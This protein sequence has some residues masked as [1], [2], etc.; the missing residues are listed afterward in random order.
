MMSFKRPPA[1]TLASILAVACCTELPATPGDA[2]DPWSKVQAALA[3][4]DTT[5][6][7]P[8]EE[9]TADGAPVRQGPKVLFR[10]KADD[11][12]VKRVHLAGNFN[13]WA[14]N[15]EGEVLNEL[16]VMQPVEGGRWYRR[17]EL[18]PGQYAYQYIIERQDGTFDWLKDPHAEES[19][20]EGHSI[21]RIAPCKEGV[22]PSGTEQDNLAAS[23]LAG[24][25][26]DGTNRILSVRKT[27]VRPGETNEVETAPW[28][29]EAGR[30]V[31]VEV[32]TPLGRSIHRAEHEVGPGT[33]TLPVPA[34]ETEGGYVL[35]VK[36]GGDGNDTV[37]GRTVLTVADSIADD[38][39]YGFYASYGSTEGDYD[40][41][42]AML[43]AMHVNAVEFYDY[44]PAHGKYAPTEFEYEFE[45]FGIAINAEDVK[46]KIDSGH[47]R[48]ILAIAYVAA[49]AASQSVY[50]Q[51]PYPMTD[52][53]GRPKVFNGEIMTEEEA[54][55]QGKP[56]WFR[57]MNIAKDS[58]WREYVLEE[59]RRTLD[60]SPD[61]L[62]AFDGFEIDTYGDS[63]GTKFYAEGSAHNGEYLTDVLRDFVDETR[64]VTRSVKPHGLVSFNSINEFG[65]SDMVNVTDFLFLE[66]WRFYNPE[67]GGLVDICFR[68]RAPARQRVVLKL[69]PADMDPKQK[70]WPAGTLARILGATMTG[71]GSLM[72][73][74]EPDEKNSTMHGLNSLFYPDHQPLR[75][76]NAELIR[77]YYGHDAM[78]FGYTHG[79]NVH[80]TAIDA[81]LEGAITRT[82]AAEGRDALVVQILRAGEDRR[83]TVDVPLPEPLADQILEVPLPGDVKPRAVYF[84]S[85][86]NEAFRL[87]VPAEFSVENGVARVTLPELRVH[88][89]VILQ[90]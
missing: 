86:D 43:A 39:R 57:I 65:V 53:E 54:D 90:Y 10:F 60:D 76:G 30:K 78:L 18:S 67:L 80:N 38:L 7:P 72:V 22:A 33:A 5:P 64:E 25:T 66:I 58:P 61:D 6:A 50:D 15:R 44:F 82:Y 51:H 83:W 26:G 34:I 52:E 41:K 31:I 68:N 19:N 9:A 35:T 79:K 42:A 49:Y 37:L 70:S 32:S 89:T 47:E 63:P 73:V 77:D 23:D 56:K 45:P 17:V 81:R 46:R 27:W 55:R 28:K 3:A 36:K 69:Y 1:Y 88:A 62:V 20:E 87:P 21:L 75:S 8:P 59:L 74:G 11:P 24:K 48:N 13:S 29:D 16:A 14:L 2:A 12:S 84:A 4:M 85:P 71:G 40:E